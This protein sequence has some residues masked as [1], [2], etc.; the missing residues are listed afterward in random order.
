[1]DN[2]AWQR[3]WR[4][5]AAQS[6]S[7]YDTPTGVVGRRFTEILAAEWRGNLDRSWNSKRPLFFS[8]V[9]FTKTLGV[10][11]SREIQ[12]MLT[13]R[14]DLWERGIHVGLVGDAEAEGAAR[15]GR[16]AS[17]GEEDDEAVAWS[18]HDTVL[19]GKL[20]PAICWATDR[21]GGGVSSWMTNSRK[22]GDR[23][24]RSSE[25]STLT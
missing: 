24:Q 20:Q 10:R 14:M 4:R 16:P 8:H 15:E 1:M 13:R 19:S 6:A 5:L 21:E 7:W 25:R 9:I 22:P 17:G 18:Y 11:R 3:R 2:A 12:S 23:L